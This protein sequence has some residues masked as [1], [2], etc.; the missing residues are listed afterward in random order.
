MDLIWLK[1]AIVDFFYSSRVEIARNNM[2]KQNK[3][4]KTTMGN[5]VALAKVAEK[6]RLEN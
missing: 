4:N 6:T 3:T 2:I 5:A 1:G